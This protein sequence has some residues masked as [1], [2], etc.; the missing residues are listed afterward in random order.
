M[1]KL[2]GCCIVLEVLQD[3]TRQTMQYGS[4]KQLLPSG[5]LVSETNA[6]LWHRTPNRSE[7]TFFLIDKGDNE[8][9]FHS[10]SADVITILNDIIKVV[11]EGLSEDGLISIGDVVLP[12]IRLWDRFVI[13]LRGG[14]MGVAITLGS[15]LGLVV[16]IVAFVLWP[17]LTVLGLVLVLV[18]YTVFVVSA[19][20]PFVLCARVFR[21]VLDQ[22]FV[23]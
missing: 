18:P 11:D 23:V 19:A 15:L 9:Y 17:V 6:S 16:I 1:V 13:L 2:M 5:T 4:L 21:Y 3:R 10:I 22:P 14:A 12:R 8:I 20:L 7:S